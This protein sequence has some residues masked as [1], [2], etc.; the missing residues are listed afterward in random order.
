MDQLLLLL[1][2]S[3]QGDI[4]L[5]LPEFRDNDDAAEADPEEDDDAW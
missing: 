5:G 2:A 4:D 1:A 3:E